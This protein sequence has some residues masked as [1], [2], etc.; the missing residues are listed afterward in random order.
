[1]VLA[2]F[3]IVDKVNRV[4][5]FKETFLIANVSPEIVFGIFFLILSGADVDFLGREFRW[6]TYTTKEALS[7]IKCVELISKKEFAT[8]VLNLEYETYVVYVA[9]LSSI[10]LVAIFGFALLDIHLS[11]RP[12]ISGLIAEK[13]FT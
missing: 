13:A 12:Q 4:R 1:M 8:I 2:A 6:R 9:L 5:F 10:S 11:Q 7:T 3:S